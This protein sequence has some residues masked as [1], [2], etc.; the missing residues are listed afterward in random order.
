MSTQPLCPH[1]HTALERQPRRKTRCPRCGSDI[2]V[3]AN[4]E[5][6]DA[7]LLKEGDAYTVD[8]LRELDGYGP[9]PA[10]FAATREELRIKNGTEPLP[11]EV[12]WLMARRAAEQATDLQD[13]KLIYY[14][15]ALFLNRMGRDARPALEKSARAELLLYKQEGIKSV[16]VSACIGDSC[17]SCRELNGKRFTVEEALS[18]M[19]IP[20][21]ACSFELY[22]E[23]HGFCRCCYDVVLEEEPPAVPP[24]LTPEEQAAVD[25]LAKR[26]AE[27]LLGKPPDSGE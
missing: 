2:Y 26:L 10:K 7:P 3:R 24:D 1:C 16:E 6:F 20:C 18:T 12:V 15:M 21:R 14:K 8:F 17:P 5:I 23:H 4:P 27:G 22:D 19:P 13:A 9:S 11:C 25:R